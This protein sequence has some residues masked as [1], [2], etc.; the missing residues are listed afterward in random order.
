MSR[1][2]KTFI[3]TDVLLYSVDRS[4]PVKKARASEVLRT[5][6]ASGDGVVSTQV[7]Q[8]CYVAATRKLGITP[9]VAKALIGSLRTLETVVVDADLIDQ[10][11]DTSILNTLSF[12]D[13]LVVVSAEKA[14]CGVL[15]TEDLS[16]G[17]VIRGVRVRSPFAEG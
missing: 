7:L 8:E 9:L 1:E 2:G 13:A 4:D 12:W 16:H 6:Q 15:I 10:A 14:A 3:D 5:L 11:I 17:Q